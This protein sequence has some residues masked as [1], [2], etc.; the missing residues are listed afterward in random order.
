[1]KK[2]LLW[3]LPG[4]LIGV[5]IILGAGRVI[6]NTSSNE[7]CMSCHIHP[8]ADA[9]WKKSTHY[10]TKSGM[11]IGCVDCHLPPKYD[12]YLWAKGKTGLRDLW[13]YWTKDSASFNWEDRRRLEVA[14]GYVFEN[15]CI[16]CH[17]NLFPAKLTK[18]GE[19]A[20]LYY[21]Q[22]KA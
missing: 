9:S 14:R 20:H 5:I 12:G 18:E 6:H 1:M 2:F 7:Y 17:E 13:S 16:K 22:N 15:S 4:L 3:F 10:D 19:N 21:N 8:A 11:R